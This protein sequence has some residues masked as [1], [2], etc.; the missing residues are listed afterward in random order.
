LELDKH[1]NTWLDRYLVWKVL[2]V[3]LEIH[4]AQQNVTHDAWE[5]ETGRQIHWAASL[6]QSAS[7]RVREKLCLKNKTKQSQQ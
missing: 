5:A 4:G 1:K 3:A 6:S 2:T 7:P